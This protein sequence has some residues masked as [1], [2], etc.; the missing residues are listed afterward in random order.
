[1][2]DYNIILNT[3]NNNSGFKCISIR[4]VETLSNV[5]HRTRAVP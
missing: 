2:I 4:A 5:T 3:R 1:M